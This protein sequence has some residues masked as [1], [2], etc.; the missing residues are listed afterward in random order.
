MT[1]TDT[2][3]WSLPRAALQRFADRVAPGSRPANVRRL[4]GG[5]DAAMHALDLLLPSGVR[6][7]LVLRRYAADLTG[8]D[9]TRPAQGWHA[10]RLLE[11]AGYPAPQPVWFDPAGELFGS[12]ALA[13]TRLPGHAQLFPHDHAAWLRELAGALAALHRLSLACLGHSGLPGPGSLR[14]EALEKAQR[15]DVLSTPH[16][17]GVALAAALRQHPPPSARAALVHGD[18]HPGNTLWLRGRLCGV[19]DWDFAC[20]EDPAFDVA[21]CRLDLAL[22]EGPDAADRFLRAYEAAAGGAVAGLRWWDLAAVTRALP[23]PARWLPG[24][25]GAGRIE[26]TAAS[27]HNRLRAHTAAALARVT[28]HRATP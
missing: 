10:L 20:I 1:A 5:I 14:A 7:R 15:P 3:P 8:Q 4:H 13:M 28:D 26:L 18:Y 23:D 19:V 22:L 24:Y 16:L 17:D 9:A 2:R 25:H 21:Y 6:R 11:Q 27:L 12:P